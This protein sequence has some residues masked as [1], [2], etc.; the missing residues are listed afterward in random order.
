MRRLVLGVSIPVRIVLQQRV[1]IVFVLVLCGAV[2]R[3]VAGI[4]GRVGW[5]DSAASDEVVGIAERVVVVVARHYMREGIRIILVDQSRL[6][7]VFVGCR[8]RS[9]SPTGKPL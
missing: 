5:G 8:A 2:S 7:H 1:I 9:P 4:R 6:A 3:T